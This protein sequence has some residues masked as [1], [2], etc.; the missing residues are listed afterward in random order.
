MTWE[1]LANL[2]TTNARI[3]I[4]MLMAMATCARVLVGDWTPPESWL[5]FL[6]VMAGIDVA[7]FATKR[8]STHKPEPTDAPET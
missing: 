7:Q 1:W 3:G 5:I 6:T 4:S 2:P 8:F